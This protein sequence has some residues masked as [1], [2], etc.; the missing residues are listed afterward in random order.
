MS[1]LAKIIV[2]IGVLFVF[3]LL[4]ATVV[5]VQSDA[6]QQ[7]PGILGLILFAALVFAIRSI[8][9]N[10]KNDDNDKDNDS[11]LQK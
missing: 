2:T 6:G 10:G 7:T 11:V 4:F 3:Y 5:G 9:K 1:K 8:W